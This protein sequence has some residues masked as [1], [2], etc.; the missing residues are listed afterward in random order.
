MDNVFPMFFTNK[1]RYENMRILKRENVF[2]L[3]F[4]LFQCIPIIDIKNYFSILRRHFFM[5][6]YNKSL[7]LSGKH[8][9][10]YLL[11]KRKERSPGSKA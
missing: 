4:Y 1:F 9:M 3:S 6:S 8:K 11:K 5:Q 2:Y 7:S 10:F